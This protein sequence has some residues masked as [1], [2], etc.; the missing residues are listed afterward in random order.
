[1]ETIPSYTKGEILALVQ[2]E[3][4]QW[5]Q[6][7]NGL[8]ESELTTPIQ[9]DDWTI[10][11]IVAH[12]YAWQQLSIARLEAGLHEC[13]PDYPA[14][15][16]AEAEENARLV[17]EGTYATYHARPWAEVYGLWRDGFLRFIALGEAISEARLLDA[18]RYD[19]LDG[20]S[21]AAVM[22]FSYEHHHIDHLEPLIRLL[23]G[24]S[25][26]ST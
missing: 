13:T 2:N 3:F 18:E 24:S 16:N 17:N 5:E 26:G 25:T 10:Q 20:Y 8:S 12:L 6:L 9:E 4:E 19:W 1:M 23:K 7:L 14:W 22:H 11:D 15:F 21:L